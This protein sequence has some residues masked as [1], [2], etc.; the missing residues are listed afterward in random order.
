MID[1][2]LIP[3][4]CVSFGLPLPA[5]FGIITPDGPGD[6]SRFCV[7]QRQVLFSIRTPEGPGDGSLLFG[8]PLPALFC[9]IT[10]PDISGDYGLFLGLPLPADLGFGVADSANC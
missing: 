3:N 7:L 5:L 9:I 10:S 8:L 1:T 6:I 2:L 4:Y